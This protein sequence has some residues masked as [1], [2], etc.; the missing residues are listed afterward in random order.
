MSSASM[1]A[2]AREALEGRAA[3][4]S[5]TLDYLDGGKQQLITIKLARP[6]GKAETLTDVVGP[7]VDLD[8]YARAMALAWLYEN[9]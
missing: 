7:S 9:A 1:M 4:T 3:V 5:V 2:A 8:A 6:D